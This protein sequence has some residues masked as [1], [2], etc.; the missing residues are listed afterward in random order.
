MISFLGCKKDNFADNIN[1]SLI[2]DTVSI[3]FPNVIESNKDFDG[4]VLYNFDE[5]NKIKNEIG[6]GSISRY[7]H[8]YTYVDTFSI[9]DPQYFNHV[10][11]D[12]FLTQSINKI[13]FKIN[14]NNK[15]KYYINTLIK[16]IIIFDTLSSDANSPAKI[17]E[18]I[19]S[20]EITVR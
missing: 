5:Y 12:T 6:S 10:K 17:S 14:V 11:K 9:N 16:D 13:N 1:T 2:N 19:L 20:K 4:E 8:L 7:I 18:V 15:G 3:N